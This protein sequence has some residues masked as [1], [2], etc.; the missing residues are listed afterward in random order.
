MKGKGEEVKKAIKRGRK[1]QR[2]GSIHVRA[3]TKNWQF[4]PKW[5]LATQ[6]M[7]NDPKL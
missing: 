6:D 2:K 3:D 1:K 4:F 7:N 5:Q